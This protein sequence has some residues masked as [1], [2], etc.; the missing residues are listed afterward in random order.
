M[1]LSRLTLNAQ[2]N[3]TRSEVDR[4]YEMHRTLSKA[5]DDLHAARVLFRPECDGAGT[6]SVIVQSLTEPDWSRLDAPREYLQEV[7]GP[8][9]VELKG[10]KQ[11]QSLRFRLRCNPSKR[12]GKKGDKDHGKRKALTTTDEVFAWLDRKA[13][14]SGFKVCEAA[15]DRVYWFHSK[16]GV[17]DKP[18][19]G[20]VFDGLLVV[21]EPADLRRAVESGIG[22]AKSFGFGLLSLAPPS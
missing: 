21:T 1:Y 3:R 9:Q 16:G 7:E 11:G 2:H 15:F 17:R 14:A 22:S 20:V 18:L 5:W 19:G 4:P 8:K 12:V 13:E 10:L 6:V